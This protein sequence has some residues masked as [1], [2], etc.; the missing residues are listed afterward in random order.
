MVKKEKAVS[1]QK[2]KE[3]VGDYIFSCF[4]YAFVT[5][6]ALIMLYPLVNVLAISFSDYYEY[7]KTPW[8]IIPKGFTWS[9][10]DY[11]MNYTGFWRSYGNTI[12][13]VIAGTVL[14]L[15]ITILMAYPLSR[16]QLK[17]KPF[18]MGMII[19][20]MVFNAGMIP[21]YINMKELGLLDT[22]WAMIM[23]YAFTAFNCI[24]M[25]N[26]FKEIPSELIEAA[27]L[28]G[29]SEPFILTKII[30]PLSKAVLA[31]ITLFLAVGYWNNYFAAQIYIQDRD[32]WPLALTLKE[33]LL[34]SSTAMAEAS[35]DASLMEDIDVKTVTIQYASI[36]LSTL[37]IICV[38]PF[39]QKYFA[40]GVLVGGVKG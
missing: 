27:E 6:I 36:I 9:G 5:L 26:F 31:S 8:M 29:A 3:T 32:L 33:L 2:V 17:G 28:E 10:Y 35:M 12:I 23:P 19:F 22:R 39:L 13:V 25:L 4:N 18:F 37:P 16:P 20:T 7:L 34:E 15:V 38:Y 30:L 1:R 40:K 21:G 24:L 11:I 14:G